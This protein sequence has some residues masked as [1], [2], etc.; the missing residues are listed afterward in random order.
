MASLMVN[1]SPSRALSVEDQ[2]PGRRFLIITA[3]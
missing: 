1:A 2:L 3:P